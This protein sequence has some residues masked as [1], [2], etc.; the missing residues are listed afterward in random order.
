MD[1]IND[2]NNNQNNGNYGQRASNFFGQL[3][4]QLRKWFEGI[5]CIVKII[6]AASVLLYLINL[7]TFNTASD[8]LS[9]IPAYSLSGF[10]IWRF[11]T[12][13]LMTTGLLSLA[14]AL[15]FW[16]SDASK[17]E[18]MKGS[19]HYLLYF[20][21]HSTI[22]QLLYA[23]LT[24]IFTAS[25]D[26]EAKL[27]YMSDG[28][29]GFLMFE[30]TILCLSFPEENINLL[31]IPYPIKA[32]Y[33]PLI[34]LTIFF[35]LSGLEL[36]V[37]VGIGYGFLYKYFIGKFLVIPS[38]LIEKLESKL[39]ARILNEPYFIRI[40][41]AQGEIN[42]FVQNNENLF[43]DNQPNND[44]SNNNEQQGGFIPFSGQG[45]QV[46]GE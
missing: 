33:Y 16:V 46:G 39:P 7:I 28:I 2:I 6:V 21:L 36:D 9:N 12:G 29:W 43:Q 27:R 32:K 30:I 11:I 41:M 18:K 42:P 5:T 22:I 23:L 37:F 25:Q 20:L 40:S 34:L 1:G 31:C 26:P 24:G 19:T 35:L 13:N 8:I 45:M 44:N 38:G 4:S 14:F 15:L 17:I 3:V 10:Q